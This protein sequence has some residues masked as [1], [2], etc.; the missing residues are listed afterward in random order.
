MGYIKSMIL[1]LSILC[2]FYFIGCSAAESRCYASPG[3]PMDP[4]LHVSAKGDARVADGSIAHPYPTIPDALAAVKPGMT[5]SIHSGIYQPFEVN[6]RCS[7]MEKAPVTISAAKGERPVIRCKGLIGIHLINVDNLIISGLEV[8][9]GTHGI[10]YESTPAQGEKALNNITIQNCIVHNINGTHGVCFYAAN[11]KAPAKNIIM[12][13]CEVFDCRC[14]SSESVAFNG[15]IDGF[16][17]CNNRIYNNDNIGIDMIGF[18]GTAKHKNRYKGNAYDVDFVR[19]GK[20]YGNSVYAISTYGN[21]A[22]CEG[23]GYDLCAGG[24]YVDGGQNIEIYNNFI[25]N[26]DIGIEV[27]TEHSPEDN[28]LFCVSGIE[29]HDNIIA[30]CKGFC[31]MAFGGYAPDLGFAKNCSFHNNTFIDNPVQIAVQRS[32]NNQ[33]HHNLFVG[34]DIGIEYNTDCAEA[35]LVNEFG[36]NYFCM[37]GGIRDLISTGHYGYALI[38]PRAMQKRQKKIE[39]RIDM[40]DGLHSNIDGFGSAFVPDEETVS[41]YRFALKKSSDS[42]K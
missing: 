33:I 41:R 7:G 12:E 3:V 28:P 10:Y 39:N 9:G 21:K 26:C 25:F 6:A 5:I 8:N 30:K 18:E 4:V 1:I 38:F 29:V 13:N 35:D 32:A 15:N 23:R 42:K 17:I 31:G 19:N 37:E 20:C 27:A 11:D 36:E 14:G 40:L 22:Y 16:T 34:G 24:I 2:V